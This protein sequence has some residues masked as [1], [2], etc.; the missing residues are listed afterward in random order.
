M[1]SIY[2]VGQKTGLLLRLDNLATTNDRKAC[3]M[4]KFQNFVSLLTDLR[5][6]SWKQ[7]LSYRK[8]IARKLRTQY[9]KRIYR[10]K[11]Y[12][13]MLK[14]RLRVIQGHWKRNHWIYH[15]RLTILVEL[16]DVEYYRDLEMWVDRSHSKTSKVVP[17]ENFGTVSIRLP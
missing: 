10:P 13:V 9:V 11:Y 17:F 15:T 12:T 6:K 2:R 3:N 5:H 4:S 16:F 7:E 8:Q 1:S 14:S